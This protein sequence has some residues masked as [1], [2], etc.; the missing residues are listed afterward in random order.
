LIISA[1]SVP[2]LNLLGRGFGLEDDL[3]EGNFGEGFR[4]GG[5]VFF[6]IF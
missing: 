3:S 5:A 2:G 4:T 1:I 6:A